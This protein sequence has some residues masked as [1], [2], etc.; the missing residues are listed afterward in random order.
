MPS[1]WAPVPVSLVRTVIAA[2]I[3]HSHCLTLRPRLNFTKERSNSSMTKLRALGAL[4]LC[5]YSLGALAESQPLEADAD[6]ASSLGEIVIT[7]QKYN[8]TIQDTPI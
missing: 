6:N 4:A 1:T 2:R 5:G 8:S 7:A 3:C